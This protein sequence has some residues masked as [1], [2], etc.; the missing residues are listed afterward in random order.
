MTIAIAKA[1]S[2]NEGKTSEELKNSVIY[3]MSS[4]AYKYQDAGYGNMFYNFLFYNPVPYNSLGNGAA[5]RISA[6]GE[7]CNSLEEVKK[8]SRVV[9]EASHITPRESKERN[10]LRSAFILR[11]RGVRKKK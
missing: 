11:E 3:E 6:A 2:E 1:L 8:I 10:V 7:F 4:F 9:T 5:M